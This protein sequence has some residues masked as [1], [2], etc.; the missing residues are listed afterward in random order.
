MD[1]GLLDG[2]SG[3]GARGFIE[4]SLYSVCSASEGGTAEVRA[5]RRYSFLNRA[6]MTQHIDSSRMYSSIRSVAIRL[7]ACHTL[8]EGSLLSPVHEHSRSVWTSASHLLNVYA[9][10]TLFP[11]RR[12]PHDHDCG[13]SR[14]PLCRF[15]L[16]IRTVPSSFDCVFARR[17]LLSRP[18]LPHVNPSSACREDTKC[19]PHTAAMRMAR[20]Q[21]K[22][23]SNSLARH[24]MHVC[25]TFLPTSLSKNELQ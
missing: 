21:L 14:T 13:P 3:D 6:S 12:R 19:T 23:S 15:L 5:S 22:Q 1:G 17:S 20:G 4:S 10:P 25:F 8:R 2:A 7:R 9:P 18:L 11:S 24:K 16:Q